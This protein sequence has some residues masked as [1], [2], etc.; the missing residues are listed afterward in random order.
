[1][2]AYRKTFGEET[3]RN[4]HNF[5]A[6]FRTFPGG[7]P[8]DITARNPHNIPG[9]N[10]RDIHSDPV[11]VLWSRSKPMGNRSAYPGFRRR[12]CGA[13][14]GVGIDATP[15]PHRSYQ[16]FN[17]FRPPKRTFYR[18]A[19]EEETTKRK[20]RLPRAPVRKKW[21]KEEDERLQ[22]G[23]KRYGDKNW[24]KIAEHV[25]TRDNKMR[26][27][28]WLHSLRPEMRVV[29]KGKWSKEEDDQLRELV[30]KYTCDGA[31]PWEMISKDMQYKRNHKQCRERWMYHLNP[32]LRS[33]GWT[34]EEDD[35]LLELHR[36]YG[37]SWKKM[38]KVLTDR[39]PEHIRRRFSWLMKSA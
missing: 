38:T 20:V 9:G 39:S 10:P 5:S 22:E 24:S 33:G 28:R 25:Q 35:K 29:K 30:K 34:A 13:N 23:V 17:G 4:P 14:F 15:T 19:D 3:E 7:N 26:R 8:L 21:K 12:D 1:M 32:N 18:Y 27:Q 2:G 36:L 37:N 31:K 6:P 11:K 16:M